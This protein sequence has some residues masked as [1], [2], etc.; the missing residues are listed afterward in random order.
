MN[1][2]RHAGPDD[3]AAVTALWERCGLTR[4]W[5][6]AGQDY[7]R[8][9]AQDHSTVLLLE[10][11]GTLIGS[12][13]VG[14]D[15]HRGWVYYLSV[16]PAHAQKGYGRLLMAAAES[17]LK[18]RGCPKLNLMVRTDNAVAQGFYTALGYEHQEVTTFGKWL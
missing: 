12:V 17:W 8:A 13:M 15:G 7:A 6:D 10:N 4:P 2:L 18:E 16:D 5:N 3:A 14:D 11:A 9:L 1:S